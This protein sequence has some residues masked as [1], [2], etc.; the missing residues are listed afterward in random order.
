MVY[1]DTHYP[2]FVIFADINSGTLDIFKLLKIWLYIHMSNY[3]WR[4]T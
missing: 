3:M 4:Y 2:N 1:V